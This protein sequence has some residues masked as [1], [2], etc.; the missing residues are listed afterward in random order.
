MSPKRNEKCA[1]LNCID[2]EG[3][4]LHRFPVSGIPREKVWL[5]RKIQTWIDFCQNPRI[6]LENEKFKSSFIGET[7]FSEDCY[8][9]SG[10]KKKRLQKGSIPTLK[11]PI[12]NFNEPMTIDETELP[13]ASKMPFNDLNKID[14]ANS[15]P[16]EVQLANITENVKL[17]QKEV[18]MLGKS[19]QDINKKKRLEQQLTRHLMTTQALTTSG[20]WEE[21]RKCIV[22]TLQSCLR[23]LLLT[24]SEIITQ[25]LFFNVDEDVQ[26]D[27]EDF[28]D[29]NSYIEAVSSKKSNDQNQVNYS[30]VTFV[31]KF[32]LP[33]FLILGKIQIFFISCKIFR[34]LQENQY[35]FQ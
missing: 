4:T 3:K 20:Y 9:F 23:K 14:L 19:Q 6:T 31:A 5:N 24:K 22:K 26:M 1:V 7:H 34:N 8:P 25:N 30:F 10:P 18:D 13:A 33:N 35:L 12:V 28:A 17:L 32:V 29:V 21:N 16:I 11:P 27:M 2:C 15:Q